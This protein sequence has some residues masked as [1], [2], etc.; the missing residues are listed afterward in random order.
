[1]RTGGS[2]VDDKNKNDNSKNIVA[3]PVIMN[4]SF[5]RLSLNVHYIKYGVYTVVT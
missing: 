3:V 5:A 1:M 2:G 4:G